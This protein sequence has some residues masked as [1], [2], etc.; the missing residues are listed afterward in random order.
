[1]VFPKQNRYTVS[2]RVW[3]LGV[4][5]IEDAV[6]VPRDQAI[7]AAGAG[8]AEDT[9]LEDPKKERG[10]SRCVSIGKYYNVNP[11]LINP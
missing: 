9:T 1:M 7:F 11:G 8:G 6:G 2:T 4:P 10:F 5:R 3:P